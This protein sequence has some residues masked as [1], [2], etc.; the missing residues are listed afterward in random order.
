MDISKLSDDQKGAIWNA[1][2]M[3]K[4]MQKRLFRTTIFIGMALIGAFVANALPLNSPLET[5]V[6]WGIMT[7]PCIMV[8]IETGFTIYLRR[9]Y[10]N[11]RSKALDLGCNPDKVSFDV[12][13]SE[14]LIT[15]IRKQNW[16]VEEAEK[17]KA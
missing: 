16:K 4:E 10:L 15:M 11:N 8:L 1:V 13:F 12:A 17:L 6:Y 2:S 3:R 14:V 5:F 9:K 7:L